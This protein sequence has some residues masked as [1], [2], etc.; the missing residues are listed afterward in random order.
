[1]HD[2][3]IWCCSSEHTRG[4]VHSFDDSQEVLDQLLAYPGISIG[5]HSLALHISMLGGK[6]CNIV[7]MVN[8][9]ISIDKQC[10]NTNAAL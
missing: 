8:M 3:D 1:M 6:A 9:I 7:I 5:K 2:S 4:V 10:C